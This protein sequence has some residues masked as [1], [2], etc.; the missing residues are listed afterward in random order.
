[1]LNLRAINDCT[2]FAELC[3]QIFL[4]KKSWSP[5]NPWDCDSGYLALD[6][7]IILCSSNIRLENLYE[8][9]SKQHFLCRV[10]S[11]DDTAA[12]LVS[13]IKPLGIAFYFFLQISSFVSVNQYD[14][15][16]HE[17]K[18]SIRRTAL[19]LL[20]G[21]LPLFDRTFSNSLIIHQVK[22][23]EI[24]TVKGVWIPGLN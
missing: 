12:M 16:S 19:F 21:G 4:P 15:K 5:I 3:G 13:K 14:W 18:H 11:H 6:R 24:T 23:K 9:L 7:F 20:T 10:F 17:W 8:K 1:M 2:L 22:T